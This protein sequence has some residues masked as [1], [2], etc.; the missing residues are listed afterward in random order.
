[1]GISL[2]SPQK[3]PP[4]D[5][6]ILWRTPRGTRWSFPGGSPRGCPREP[7]G[8]ALAAAGPREMNN[9]GFWVGPLLPHGSVQ[10]Q[11]V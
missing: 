1:M 5:L 4:G 3:I 9:L 6:T 11:E 7:L 2:A 8:A 10:F